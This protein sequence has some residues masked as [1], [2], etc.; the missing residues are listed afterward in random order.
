MN[1]WAEALAAGD[2]EVATTSAASIAASTNTS[3]RGTQHIPPLSATS[4]PGT[5]RQPEIPAIQNTTPPA[6]NNLPTNN[7]AIGNHPPTL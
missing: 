3:S 7:E 5:E 2:E 4:D 1:D 6:P